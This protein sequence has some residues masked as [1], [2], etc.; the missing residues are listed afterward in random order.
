MKIDDIITIYDKL[1]LQSFVLRPR[2][3]YDNRIEGPAIVV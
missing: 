1:T 2:Q 3:F